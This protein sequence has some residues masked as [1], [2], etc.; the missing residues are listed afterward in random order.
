[1]F[2]FNEYVFDTCLINK[3]WFNKKNINVGIRKSDSTPYRLTSLILRFFIY[4]IGIIMP[5]P[6]CFYD[7]KNVVTYVKY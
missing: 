2:L 7:K 6:E 3:L 1:M 4:K 5:M